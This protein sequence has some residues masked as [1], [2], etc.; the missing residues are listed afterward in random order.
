MGVLVSAIWVVGLCLMVAVIGAR[1][2]DTAGAIFGTGLV[3]FVAGVAADLGE[4]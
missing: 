3:L 4:R 1:F 2:A